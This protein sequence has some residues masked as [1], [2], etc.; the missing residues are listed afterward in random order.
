MRTFLRRS[1][2]W[3]GVFLAILFLAGGALF[4]Y[5]VSSLPS[6]NGR[7]S[8]PVDRPASVS[9][10]AHGIVSIEAASLR[11]AYVALGYVHAQDR[12]AQMEL[13]RRFGAGRL[14]EFLGD[15]TFRADK[16]SRLIGFHRLAEQQWRTLGPDY[17]A[18]LT[19]YSAGVNAYLHDHR[20]AWPLDLL[21]IAGINYRPE[22]WTPVDCLVWGRIMAWRLSQNYTDERRNAALQNILPDPLFTAIAGQARHTASNNW[23]IGPSLS[24]SGAALL[25]ND[26]HLSIDSP[27]PWYLMRMHTPEGTRIGA[28]APGMP[29]LVIGTNGKVAWGFTATGG[30]TQDLF[31]EKPVAAAAY[32]TPDGT[33]PFET[34]Q[35]V[36]GVGQ[37]RR[38]VTFRKTRH[39][40]VISDLDTSPGGPVLALAWTGSQPDDGS[41]QALWDMNKAQNAAQFHAALANFHSPEQNVVYADRAGAVGFVAAGRVP[42]RSALKGNSLV[43]VPGESGASDWKGWIPFS[44]LPQRI[45]PPF[46]AT[47]NNDITPDAYPY[48]MAAKWESPYRVDRITEMI[49]SRSSLSLDDMRVMQQD[50]LSL[51]A[52]QLTPSLLAHARQKAPDLAALLAE[53]DFRM[54]RALPQPAFFTYWLREWAFLLL[55][56]SLGAQYEDWFSWQVPQLLAV[57]KICGCP[58]ERDQAFDLAFQKIS[59]DLGSDPH[60]WA[61]GAVHRD[62]YVHPILSHL[63]LLGTLLGADLPVDGDNFTVNRATPDPLDLRDIHGPSMRFLVDMADPDHALFALAGGQSGNPLSRHYKDLLPFWRNGEY[64]TMVA[65]PTDSLTVDPDSHDS[66]SRLVLP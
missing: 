18:A 15:R 57:E 63:P 17:Q 21:L 4:F 3:L 23:V 66:N 28:T 27:S 35:E 1:S 20:G 54:D 22:A 65:P 59:R 13:M 52:R 58:E 8:L 9:R 24:H 36:I 45:D 2:I 44:E 40:P 31:I 50:T 14:S 38:A 6:L 30:D 61:W 11:D 49:A 43:P 33:R 37:E 26:P 60:R 32:A 47:A 42:I 16:L 10:D 34:W 5:L 46:A 41:A 48:F 12:W 56:R 55:G 29:L 7:V 53:W 64:V 19:A 39:G 51:V 62:R 25:A